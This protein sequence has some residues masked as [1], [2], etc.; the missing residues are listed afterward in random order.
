M[1]RFIIIYI[2]K[3]YKHFFLHLLMN[4]LYTMWMRTLQITFMTGCKLFNNANKL[5]QHLYNTNKYIRNVS[6]VIKTYY[7]FFTLQKIEPNSYP[8]MS[9]SWLIPNDTSLTERY[10]L[11]EKYNCNYDEMFICFFNSSMTIYDMVDDYFKT[12][13][14]ENNENDSSVFIMTILNEYNEKC[15]FVTRSNKEIPNTLFKKSN[16]KF[17]FI[18]YKNPEMDNSIELRLDSSWFYVGNELFTPTFVLRLLNYQ[19]NSFFFDMNYTISIMDKDINIIEFGSD[20]Y[21]ILT[22]DSYEVVE[23]DKALYY[24]DDEEYEEDEEDDEEYEEDEEDEEDDEEE[25]EEEDDEDDEEYEEED[26]EDDED[27]EYEEEDEDDEEYEYY[28]YQEDKDEGKNE[29]KED[30]DDDDEQY[31]Q[32]ETFEIDEPVKP[33]EFEFEYQFEEYTSKNE[34]NSRESVEP[35]EPGELSEREILEREISEKMN[36]ILE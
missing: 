30:K 7:C 34:N 35:R 20:N 11:V 31:D 25:Y 10:T 9:I 3:E 22:E 17:V 8:N 23:N 14:N 16:S 32:I 2:K 1:Y 29:D 24:E 5:Y 33:I 15:R 4:F 26:D 19:S 28:E 21:I 13:C 36:D 27:Y 6:D 12:F 18:E